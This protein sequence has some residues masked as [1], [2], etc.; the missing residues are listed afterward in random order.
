MPYTDC[1][2]YFFGTWLPLIRPMSLL[3]QET[4]GFERTFYFPI[5][6]PERACLDALQSAPK[7][8]AHFCHTK[9]VSSFTTPL[10]YHLPQDTRSPIALLE[11]ICP[12]GGTVVH[13]AFSCVISHPLPCML[14]WSCCLF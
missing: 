3:Y 13:L 6:L 12:S 9:I 10:R 7:V 2:T 5:F 14:W 4:Q 1:D 8:L 11:G